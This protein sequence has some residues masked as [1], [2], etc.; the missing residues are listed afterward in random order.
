MNIMGKPISGN[1]NTKLSHALLSRQQEH[2]REKPDPSA[3]T[4]LHPFQHEEKDPKH[5]KG[6]AYIHLSVV[7]PHL[8]GWSPRA[9]SPPP[10]MGRDLA[11]KHSCTCTHCLFYQLGHAGTAETASHT[12]QYLN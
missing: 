12:K 11:R 2:T 5:Q 4:L 8:I 10:R 7:C 3:A 6:A 9:S 1:R